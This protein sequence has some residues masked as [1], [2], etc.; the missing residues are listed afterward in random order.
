M[1]VGWHESG[2]AAQPYGRLERRAI[3]FGSGESQELSRSAIPDN[4]ALAPLGGT[5]LCA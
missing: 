3:G 4:S 1:V 2:D 5:P